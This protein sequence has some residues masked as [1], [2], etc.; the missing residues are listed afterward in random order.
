MAQQTI[1]LE[2]PLNNFLKVE[3]LYNLYSR[4]AFGLALKI[5]QNKESAEDV[6]HEAFLRFLRNQ[7]SY[8]PAKGAF[9]NWLLTVVYNIC[10]DQIRKNS[11]RHLLSFE[12]PKIEQQLNY[13][14]DLHRS[15][16][17]EV[18]LKMQRLYIQNALNGLSFRQREYIEL[19]FFK[20]LS[21]SEIAYVTGMPLGTVKCQIRQGLLKL[22][23]HL[24]QTLP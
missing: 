3:E 1:E 8:D 14:V 20:G 7:T 23:G 24:D 19:A 16:D 17:E 9:L 10:I 18:W 21:H 12:H 15:V 5:L 6:T 2:V 13:L 11:N 4:A 22:K